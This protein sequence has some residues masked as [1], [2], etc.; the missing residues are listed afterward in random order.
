MHIYKGWRARFRYERYIIYMSTEPQTRSSNNKK[1]N[2]RNFSRLP[3]KRFEIS[4]RIDGTRRQD[5][6]WQCAHE[7]SKA[8][9]TC[10]YA[11]ASMY[12]SSSVFYLARLGLESKSDSPTS[13]QAGWG[14][15]ISAIFLGNNDDD[16]ATS[17]GVWFI[18]M[19]PFFDLRVTG[20][21]SALTSAKELADSQR[22]LADITSFV[23]S[24][25][26]EL[27]LQSR[28][29]DRLRRELDRIQER[30]GE[31]ESE[32]GRGSRSPRW[33]PRSPRREGS[34]RG[35][36]SIEEEL[37][38]TMREIEVLER[39]KARL[40]DRMQEKQVGGGSRFRV[41]YICGNLCHQ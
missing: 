34:G 22:R 36:D 1:K 6:R 13:C 31:E 37:A 20:Q 28:Q 3:V 41:L 38:E 9:W 30:G 21:D 24:Q 17:T 40:S 7:W 39:R 35:N 25:R 23:L 16:T 27:D 29:N 2:R 10:R 4:R 32:S 18:S 19:H 11:L 8:Q 5:V 15:S 33:S 12:H 14:L 26:N